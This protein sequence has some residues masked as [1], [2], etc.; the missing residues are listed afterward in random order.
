M[1]Y[2]LLLKYTGY[3]KGPEKRT[4]KLH[5]LE[6]CGDD[7]GMSTMSSADDGAKFVYSWGPSSE[8][9]I[10]Q[11]TGQIHCFKQYFIWTNQCPLD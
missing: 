6:E 3:Q 8:V 7:S 9:E 1:S 2:L 11:N 4:T 5:F 10:I